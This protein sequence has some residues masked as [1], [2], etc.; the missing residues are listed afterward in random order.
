MTK[1]LNEEKKSS[2]GLMSR[3]FPGILNR[4]K[5]VGNAPIYRLRQIKKGRMM[6]CEWFS[7]VGPLVKVLRGYQYNTPRRAKFNGKFTIF[8]CQV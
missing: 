6:R 7:A 4:F 2:Q 3:E 1:D 8:G 5:T